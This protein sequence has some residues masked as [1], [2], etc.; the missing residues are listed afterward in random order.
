MA[1]QDLEGDEDE[2]QAE[3]NDGEEEADEEKN[4]NV[5]G[6]YIKHSR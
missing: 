3:V 1:K 6:N 4:D 2:E 5:V